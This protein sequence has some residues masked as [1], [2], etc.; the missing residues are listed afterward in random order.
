[1]EHGDFELGI[2]MEWHC[3][4]CTQVFDTRGKRDNHHRREH[5]N[6]TIVDR[7][8]RKQLERSRN[9][10]FECICRNMYLTVGALTKHRKKCKIASDIL[11]TREVESMDLGKRF[12]DTEF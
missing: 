6:V 9:G 5:Q 2:G 4:S 8:L 10:K 7:G 11:N 12:A 3:R 1:M